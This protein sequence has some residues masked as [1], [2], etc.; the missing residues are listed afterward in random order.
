MSHTLATFHLSLSKTEQEFQIAGTNA[1]MFKLAQELHQAEALDQTPEEK[2]LVVVKNTCASTR[3][4]Q[5]K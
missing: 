3:T 2:K 4:L 1:N 5:I